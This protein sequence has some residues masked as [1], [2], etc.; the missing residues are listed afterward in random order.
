MHMMALFL[1]QKANWWAYVATDYLKLKTNGKTESTWY[2]WC[3]R[4]STSILMDFGEYY[5]T[6]TWI[7]RLKCIPIP[8][9]IHI[10]CHFFPLILHIIFFFFW[11]GVN[12][13]S[14]YDFFSLHTQAIDDI[15]YNSA[16]P[17]WCRPR[18]TNY[19]LPSLG[20]NHR[21]V[22]INET[23]K[24]RLVLADGNGKD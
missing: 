3:W 1:D 15:Q 18:G 6:V 14:K 24:E 11:G 5:M 23:Y 12:A 17:S 8:S 2:E 22:A 10:S 13:C 7:L 16:L 19:L 20:T 9:R 4:Y 21:L